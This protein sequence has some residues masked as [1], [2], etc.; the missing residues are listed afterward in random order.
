[1]PGRDSE[2]MAL[3]L[4]VLGVHSY[5]KFYFSPIPEGGEM[6]STPYLMMSLKE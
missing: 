1:M 4:E 5:S 2:K 6:S 3:E